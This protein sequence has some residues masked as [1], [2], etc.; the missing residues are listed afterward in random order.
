MNR[1]SGD[2]TF[3]I[4]QF[5]IDLGGH[6]SREVIPESCHEAS[7]KRFVIFGF[8]KKRIDASIVAGESD[9]NIS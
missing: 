1:L 3:R 8:R 7:F 9:M 4:P 2:I 6:E 5:H